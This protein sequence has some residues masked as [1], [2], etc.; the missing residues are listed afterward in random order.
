MSDMQPKTVREMLMNLRSKRLPTSLI[1]ASRDSSTFFE[2][3]LPSLSIVS[4]RA[5]T[6]CET[7]TNFPWSVVNSVPM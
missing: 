5:A 7:M 2:S 1:A 4:L 3:A 6:S